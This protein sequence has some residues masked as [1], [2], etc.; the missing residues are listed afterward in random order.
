MK[1]LPHRYYQYLQGKAQP[2]SRE[3]EKSI[4][5]IQRLSGERKEENDKKHGKRNISE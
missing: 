4:Y 5:I 3:K 1:K 2:E